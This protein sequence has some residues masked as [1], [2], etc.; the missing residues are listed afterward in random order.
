MQTV[1]YNLHT[2]IYFQYNITHN[3][4]VIN[5]TFKKK[6]LVIKMLQNQAK[7]HKNEQKQ[8]RVSGV[9]NAIY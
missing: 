1:L 8:R 5:R 4:M 9:F 2:K 3:E 7:K 6:Q